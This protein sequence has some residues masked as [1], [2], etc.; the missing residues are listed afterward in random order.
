MLVDPLAEQFAHVS[1]FNYAENEPV[2]HIDL[3][4][5]QAVLAVT[6]GQDVRYRGGIFTRGVNGS[7]HTH[8]SSNRTATNDFVDAL[9]EATANDPNGIG[10]VSIWSHGIP[11]E[12]FGSGAGAGGIEST[13][14]GA[15]ETAISNGEISFAQGAIIYLGACNAGTDYT[16]GSLA[17]NLADITGVEVVAAVD[18]QVGSV[19]ESTEILEYTTAYPRDH[20]FHS[21]TAGNASQELGSRVEVFGLQ[22]R[23]QTQIQNF[24]TMIE[25]RARDT[26]IQPLPS[27]P[28]Q[29]IQ[30]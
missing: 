29:P 12:A 7:T 19:N 17:Q 27:L 15:L 2:G 1:P 16:G 9:R 18:D 3:W 30:R 5:L 23:A 20:S 13:D 11:G 22:N 21:F 28:I 10:F 25:N 4:G 26:Q 24:N 8:L 6:L 14:L